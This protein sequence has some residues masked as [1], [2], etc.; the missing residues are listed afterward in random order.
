MKLWL[1]ILFWLISWIEPP[2][3]EKPI[4]RVVASAVKLAHS[5][6]A[7]NRRVSCFS[8]TVVDKRR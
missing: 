8:H 7:L 5:I 2:N 3:V 4:G 1:A 6:Q